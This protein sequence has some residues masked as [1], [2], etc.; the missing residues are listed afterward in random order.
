MPFIPHQFV[1]LKQKPEWQLPPTLALS[2][3][4]ESHFFWVRVSCIL[5]EKR[6]TVNLTLRNTLSLLLRRYKFQARGWFYHWGISNLGNTCFS[7]W[8]Q[9]ATRWRERQ[10]TSELRWPTGINVSFNHAFLK[11]LHHPKHQ[12]PWANQSD[13]TSML[14]IFMTTKQL[15]VIKKLDQ[16]TKIT[17]SCYITWFLWCQSHTL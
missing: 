1:C 11:G 13:S 14:H 12:E 9:L 15:H 10:S 17:F 16:M 8:I 4:H 6:V 2:G 5:G 3:K 7:V